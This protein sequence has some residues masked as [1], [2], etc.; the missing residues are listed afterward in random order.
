MP[1]LRV[2]VFRNEVADERLALVHGEEISGDLLRG[3][4]EGRSLEEEVEDCWEDL[5]GLNR[6]INFDLWEFGVGED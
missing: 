5:G 2:L 1:F 3:W 6:E 4:V